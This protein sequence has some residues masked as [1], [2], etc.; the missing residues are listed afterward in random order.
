MGQND[1]VETPTQYKK[2]IIS[3]II[4]IVVLVVIVAFVLPKLG[5]YDVAINEI[6]AMSNFEIAI[7]AAFTIA[8]ILIYVT[9]YLAALPSLSFKNGFVLR[10]T[11]FLISN[12]IPGGGAIGI[13]VQAMMLSSYG[14]NATKTSTTIVLT[15]AWNILATI[16]LPGLAAVVLV[17]TGNLDNDSAL[18]AGISIV[19]TIVVVTLFIILIKNVALATK[20]SEKIE[21]LANKVSKKY[22]KQSKGKL[23]ASIMEFRQ[24]SYQITIQRWPQLILSNLFQQLGQFSILY[25]ALEILSP[26]PI[27]IAVIFGAFAV[28]RYGTFIPLTPGGIGTVDA[29]LVSLL[30][31]TGIDNDVAL[32][33]TLIWRFATLFPQ[34]A[35]GSLTFIYWR[36]T[37]QSKTST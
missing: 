15:G 27:S 19:I 28:A 13:G 11:S 29:I 21:H 37:K 30:I 9:P 23:K 6:K 14:Y 3:S 32:A 4:T 25:I 2:I 7:L 10:Q 24:N 22:N 20:V 12:A 31:Q 1:T 8:N 36:L 18:A 17:L 33:A 5:D 26:D 16:S 34:M 35:I